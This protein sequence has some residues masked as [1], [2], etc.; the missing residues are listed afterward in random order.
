M[1]LRLSSL[2]IHSLSRRS[3]RRLSA[4]VENVGGAP[5]VIATGSTKLQAKASRQP[6]MF[7]SSPNAVKRG[8]LRTQRSRECARALSPGRRGVPLA[9]RS[10]KKIPARARSRDRTQT[11]A[12]TT[13]CDDPPRADGSHVRWCR[14]FVRGA[15]KRARIT[16]SLP[17]GSPT[18]GVTR[19]LARFSSR[20]R[21]RRRTCLGA[22]Q[23]QPDAERG[24]QLV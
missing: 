13:R 20:S 4:R 16:T 8:T 14:T 6:S 11:R 19:R 24:D 18:A 2:S 1:E 5:V 15:R 23:L 12:R 7:P 9:W 21:S 22:W 10:R 3:R 17:I